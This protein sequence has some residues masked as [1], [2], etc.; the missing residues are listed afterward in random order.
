MSHIGYLS[1][2][3]SSHMHA[4]RVK[5]D[6]LRLTLVGIDNSFPSVILRGGIEFGVHSRSTFVILKSISGG[7]DGRSTPLRAYR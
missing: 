2:T 1:V 7:I 5:P 3:F 6:L 4:K